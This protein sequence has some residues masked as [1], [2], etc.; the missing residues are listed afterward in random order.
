MQ[1]EVHMDSDCV[2]ILSVILF[3]F[4]RFGGLSLNKLFINN[5]STFKARLEQMIGKNNQG[6]TR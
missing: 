4:N 6:Y 2:L 1:L 5:L 3:N